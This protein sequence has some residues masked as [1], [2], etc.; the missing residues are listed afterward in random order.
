MKIKKT[1]DGL[2]SVPLFFFHSLTLYPTC[3]R[4]D[5][6]SLVL[7]HFHSP[8]SILLLL[9]QLILSVQNL[10]ILGNNNIIRN[11]GLPH[12]AGKDYLNCG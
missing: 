5:R 3:S 6:G 10:Q 11:N 2:A 12:G 8:L 4:V 9:F 1:K 7:K